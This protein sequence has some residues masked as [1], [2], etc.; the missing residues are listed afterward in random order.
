MVPTVSKSQAAPSVNT[1]AKNNPE[2]PVILLQ[3]PK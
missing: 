2:E 1:F 3:T